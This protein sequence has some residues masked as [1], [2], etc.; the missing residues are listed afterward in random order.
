MSDFYLPAL[1]NFVYHKHNVKMLSKNF[2][3]VKRRTT[4]MFKSGILLTGRDYTEQLSA[5]FYL[6]I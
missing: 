5:K 6:E 3:G 4:F 2:Y 1:E